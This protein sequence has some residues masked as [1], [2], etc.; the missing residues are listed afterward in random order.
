MPLVD[1]QGIRIHFELEGQGAPLICMHGFSSNRTAWRSS[2]FVAPL[3]Q[4]YR[5][6]LID[7]RGHGQSAKPH[8]PSAYAFQ[9]MVDDI[10]AVLDIL[11]IDRTHYLGYSMGGELGFEL[12]KRYP[13][14]VRSL[15]IGGSSPYN[16]ETAADVDVLLDLYGRG[17]AQGVE[18]LIAG[19]AAWGEVTPAQEARLR[20]AD[21]Q[22]QLAWLH[23]YR[24]HIPF[25]GDDL[26]A[27]SM[28]CLLYAGELD[29]PYYSDSKAAAA[30]LPNATFV[31]LPGMKHAGAG[32]A[33]DL[34]VPHIQDFLAAIP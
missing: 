9:H 26:A 33:G 34:L 31:G 20:S 29:E 8:E 16:R 17:V 32:G 25:Y 19:F 4:A 3:R 12:A 28:P 18:A 23:W 13:Q 5:L 27:M 1:N 21:L 15:I 10:I 22:A 24:A 14:R 30:Q 11:Q 2:G 7:A 6:I